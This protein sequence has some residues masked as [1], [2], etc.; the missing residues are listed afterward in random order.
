MPAKLPRGIL[1]ALWWY[2][3][4]TAL[5]CT[6]HIRNK[7]KKPYT[8][9]STEVQANNSTA[10]TGKTRLESVQDC[11]IQAHFL[12]RELFAPAP[13]KFSHSARPVS[14][15]HLVVVL[16][17]RHVNCFTTGECTL[18]SNSSRKNPLFMFRVPSR[19]RLS[20]DSWFASIDFVRSQRFPNRCLGSDTKLSS[21]MPSC[22]K[23]IPLSIEAPVVLG[24]T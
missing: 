17:R 3:L 23:N 4:H 10:F 22:G 9:T 18:R 1:V 15:N 13:K 20:M 24:S 21:A 5:F 14:S 6:N 11:I 2:R 8:Q 16:F 12:F 19:T 7:S